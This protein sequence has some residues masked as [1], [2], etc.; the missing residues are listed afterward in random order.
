MRTF[1]GK[2]DLLI[3]DHAGNIDRHGSPD[4]KRTWRLESE[5]QKAKR[6]REIAELERL[7]LLGYDSIEAEL[8]AKRR[9][10]EET[11]SVAEVR[12]LL[13]PYVKPRTLALEIGIFLGRSGIRPHG[14]THQTR[15]AKSQIDH[16][17]IRFSSGLTIKEC[18]S[19]LGMKSTSI[20]KLF[21]K[22]GVSKFAGRYLKADVEDLAAS[23]DK[24]ALRTCAFAGCKRGVG[25]QP[26]Q[27][28]HYRR[29][30]GPQRYCSISCR[31]AQNHR[32][33]KEK[34]SQLK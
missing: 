24:P 14:R 13:R 10:Q 9:L 26:A 21:S 11:Y 32:R 15:Y 7:H 2:A 6:E 28:V 12:E 18:S 31:R 33:S 22:R 30:C 8:E 3:L 34:L 19:L 17:L 25:G 1:P 4:E 5:A 16:L 20:S 23:L 27:F 29:P